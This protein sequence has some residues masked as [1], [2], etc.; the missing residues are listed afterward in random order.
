M[1]LTLERVEGQ[2][3][4]WLLTLEHTAH[5]AVREL[6]FKYFNNPEVSSRGDAVVIVFSD[7]LVHHTRFFKLVQALEREAAPC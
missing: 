6:A 7:S 4:H 3:G 5:V 1:N 2:T